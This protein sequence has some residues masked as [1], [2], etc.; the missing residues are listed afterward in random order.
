MPQADAKI[1]LHIDAPLS[2]GA[3]IALSRDQAHYLFSVMRRSVG[4]AVLV[5]NRRDGEWRAH[6]VEAGKRAGVLHAAA[7]TR[8]QA[9]G[10]DLWLCF[11]PIKKARTDFIAEK[12]CEM[13]CTRLVPV[14]TR[15][16]NADRVRVDRLR[17]H[18]VEAAEQ[19]GLLSVPEVVEPVSLDALLAD[20]PG[21]R[22]LMFCDESGAGAP[23]AEVLR[24]AGPGPW[25]V[26]IGPEGGFAA[27]EAA[28]LTALPYAHAV[29]LGPR[30][31]RADTA[32]VAALA[33]WQTV[34]GDWT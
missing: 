5:F 21:D 6:V 34:L 3:A 16:T 9:E 32:A 15:H 25:A 14:F 26:L 33:V 10:P 17:A 30:I 29:S 4:D 2:E 7:Q 13:G 18:A 11:A 8:E 12:A 20:W 24:K 27:E 19:C 22:A 31:L 1:R 23:A 28:R